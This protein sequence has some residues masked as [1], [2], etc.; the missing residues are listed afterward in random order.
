MFG[1]IDK[2]VLS[3]DRAAIERELTRKVP[4]MMESRGFIPAIDH[5]VPPDVPFDNYAFYTKL[6]R[7]MTER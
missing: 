1:G 5:S 3:K 2:R 7:E 4:R 6:L